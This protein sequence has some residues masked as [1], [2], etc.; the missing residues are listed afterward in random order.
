MYRSGNVYLQIAINK[1]IFMAP[2]KTFLF[3]ISYCQMPATPKNTSRSSSKRNIQINSRNGEINATC[4]M[5][6]VSK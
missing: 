3:F 6:S 1:T 2:I 4:G 5:G